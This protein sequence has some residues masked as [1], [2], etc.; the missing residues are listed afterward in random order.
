MS[1]RQRIL[2]ASAAVAVALLLASNVH[3]GLP[4]TAGD[5][6][7]Q[8]EE[9]KWNVMETFD[10]NATVPEAEP[11][12]TPTT[13]NQIACGDIIR[14]GS[15]VTADID[16]YVFSATAGQ[17]LTLGTDT[18]GGVDVDTYIYLVDNTGTTALA[19]NDDD[20]PLAYSL[21]SS[22]P[23][24]YT[25]IYFLVVEGYST[26]DIGDYSA[27]VSCASPPPPSDCGIANYKGDVQVLTAPLPIPDNNLAGV[28]VGTINTAAD[29][30][31]FLDVVVS[32]KM[33]HTWIGD[34]AATLTYDETCDGTPEASSRFICRPGRLN[35]D[36]TL[37]SPFGCSSNLACA[38][39]LYFSDAGLNVLGVSPNGCGTTS[40]VMPTGCYQ[41]GTNAQP[42]SVFD[43]LLKG[44]CW[45]LNVADHGAGDTG[46]V[47]EWAVYTLNETVV[48]VT[49]TTW[50]AIKSLRLGN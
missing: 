7:P 23:A 19:Q 41:G 10:L 2:H 47:C 38:N 26:A 16:F 49:P 44:G 5:K 29:L 35:C 13:A 1:S 21:I 20:G 18:N 42:L 46:T 4:R 27:F 11:N 12:N 34:L 45:K 37:G 43:H 30:T 17:L 24:P 15:L 3:A 8:A 14:P 6:S 33:A 36:N 22:F 25:G 31:R 39:T 48:P 50:G 9:A 28:D 32:L 40:T